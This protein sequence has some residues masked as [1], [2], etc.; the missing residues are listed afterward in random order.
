MRETAQDQSQTD[1]GP[2]PATTRRRVRYLHASAAVPRDL[3]VEPLLAGVQTVDH[4]LVGESAG[5]DRQASQVTSEKLGHVQVTT[6]GTGW[7]KAAVRG[8]AQS[9]LLPLPTL[10]YWGG[11]AMDGHAG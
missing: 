10:C 8:A 6:F 7:G 4:L 11:S 3:Q 1:A 2:Q 5:P 9:L